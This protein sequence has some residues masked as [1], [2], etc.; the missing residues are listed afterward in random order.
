MQVYYYPLATG[1]IG[2]T[3]DLRR[4]I[5]DEHSLGIRRPR[6]TVLAGAEPALIRLC[7]RF[8]VLSKLSL[9]AGRA[10]DRRLFVVLFAFTRKQLDWLKQ[11]CDQFYD[12]PFR[13]RATSLLRFA[14]VRRRCESDVKHHRS[15][16]VV[17]ARAPLPGL[18]ASGVSAPACI[19]LVSW[20]LWHGSLNGSS[21]MEPLRPALIALM[22]HNRYFDPQETCLEQ[23]CSSIVLHVDRSS[24]CAA[25]AQIVRVANTQQWVVKPSDIP[26][27]AE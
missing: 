27:F 17:P 26:P 20:Q 5:C 2:Q 22:N 1:Y 21:G 18:P 7:F 3:N 4:R 14:H 6:L 13:V 16:A 24:P 8:A 19:L 11:A 25:C 15:Y 12:S 9:R 23:V 10:I